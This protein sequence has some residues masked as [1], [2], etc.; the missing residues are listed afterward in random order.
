MSPCAALR[1]DHYKQPTYRVIAQGNDALLADGVRVVAVPLRDAL[2]FDAGITIK[3][4][5]DYARS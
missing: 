5:A 1:V 4:I 3:S 2:L